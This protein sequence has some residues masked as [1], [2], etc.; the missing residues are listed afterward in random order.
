MSFKPIG[1][2]VAIK[3]DIGG[4]KTTEGGII[5]TDNRPSGG[6][7]WSVVVAIGDG[8]QEDIRVGDR[9]MWPL[10]QHHGNT[11]EDLDIIHETYIEMVER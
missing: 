10:S 7:V 3:T 2:F 4:E 9:V 11:Y 5:Y 6:M 8:V 1:K